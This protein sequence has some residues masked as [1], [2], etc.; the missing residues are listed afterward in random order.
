MQRRETLLQTK[1]QSDYRSSSSDSDKE[2]M[3]KFQSR[4][5]T[6]QIVRS[7]AMPEQERRYIDK[8]RHGIICNRAL[9]EEH[10]Q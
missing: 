3:K 1:R 9:S 2:L 8:L 7:V 4:D 10:P 6:S 5:Y